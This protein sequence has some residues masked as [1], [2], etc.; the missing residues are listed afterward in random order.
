MKIRKITSLTAFLSFIV[1]LLTSI[2]LYIVPH[3][4]VAY[5]SDWHLWGLTK[6]QWGNLHINVGFLFLLSMFV[7]IYLNW[8]PIVNYLKNT[9]KNLIVFTGDFNIAMVLLTMFCLGTYFEIPPMSWILNLNESIKEAGIAKYGEP[10]YG[11][12]ELSSLKVFAKKTELDLDESLEWLRKAGIN[13]QGESQSVLEVAE[14]NQMT[15]KEVYNAMK[16]DPVESN[17]TPSLPKNPQPGLGKKTL[18][19]LCEQ[20][21]LDI[22]E[23]IQILKDDNIVAEENMSLKAIAENNQMSP[24]DVYTILW[25]KTNNK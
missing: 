14:L 1:L 16:P 18:N 17:Q 9:S 13:F 21:R 11:H 25:E 12:A 3:G 24:I 10:P 19:E 7:H 22:A 15:P 6:T 8:K 4:R 23:V 2:I 20:Y 5:W